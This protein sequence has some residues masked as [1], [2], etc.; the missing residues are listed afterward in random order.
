MPDEEKKA[1][2]KQF[3]WLILKRSGNL[4]NRNK[5]HLEQLKEKNEPLYEMYL[6][7]EDF[8]DIFQKGRTRSEGDEM[9]KAWIDDV[10]KLK[11]KKLKSF[12]RT[13]LKRIDTILNWF[14]HPISNGKAEGV[15][16][17]IKSLLKRAYGYKDFDYFIAKILQKCGYLMDYM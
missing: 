4:S 5:E 13:V 11:C 16:N 14:D 10:L 2:K 3:R 1:I 6:L 12:A 7:K 8:L 17:V 9:I 15:N